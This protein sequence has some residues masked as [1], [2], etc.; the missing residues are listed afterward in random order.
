MLFHGPLH[1]F[2]YGAPLLLL[3]LLL[4]GCSG[5]GDP[6]G[7]ARG[8]GSPG[9]PAPGSPSAPSSDP[10][11]D[12]AP[13]SALVDADPARL[14]KNRSA[15]LALI[16]KV[17]AEP[18][19]F[20]PGVVKR[21]PY[22]SDPAT[23]PVLGTDC[24]WARQKPAGNV[25]ATVTRN[26]EVP[27]VKGRGPVRLAAVVTVH[28]TRQDARWE[29]AESLE[30]T[31]RCPTQQLRQG[32][33]IGS[34]ISAALLQGESAQSNSED[35][36]NETGQFRSEELGGPYPYAW[37]QAQTLQFTVAVTGK[38]AK[39][40]TEK[41]LGDLVAQAQ[42]AMLVRLQSAVEKQS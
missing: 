3:P 42:G 20:G 28:R 34:M 32:E 22:E 39:G 31:M 7:D 11:P 18:D 21:S 2:R 26:F 1:G 8:Q 10:D 5:G 23:W 35:A 41:E 13:S 37:Q 14:P 4:A 6:E 36:L 19:S 17:I 30:E 16:G 25:L 29:M 15:A 9:V 24:V 12:P 38:G 27:A 40:R 33:L